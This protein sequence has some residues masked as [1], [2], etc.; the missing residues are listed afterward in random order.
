M[1]KQWLAGG[2]R[3][4]IL[5]VFV[6]FTA[7]PFYWMLITAFKT[8]ARSAQS[9]EQSLCVQHASDLGPRAGAV[10]R[11]HVCAMAPQ[12]GDGRRAGGRHYLALAAVP[13]GYSLARLTGRLG[14]QRWT[15]HLPA[16]I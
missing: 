8:D 5:A 11:H 1:L 4:G 13:A 6:T 10:H 7:F 16:R 2:S 15:L 9:E 12:H 3:F 14:E